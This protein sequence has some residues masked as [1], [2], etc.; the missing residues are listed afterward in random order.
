MNCPTFANFDEMCEKAKPDLLMVTTVDDFH[1]EYIVKGLDRGMDVMTEK[2]MVINEQQCQAVLDAEKRN[3]R[4]IIVTFN[5]RYAPKHRTVKEVLMSGEIGTRAVGRFRLVPRRLSRGGLLPPLAPAAQ[6]GGG[7]L[8]VHKATHHFDLVNW[9][10][11]ADPVEVVADG[12]LQRVRQERPFRHTNCR[13]CPH[14]KACRFHY[15]ITTNANRMKLYV[16]N[17]D[18]DQLLPRRLRVP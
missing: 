6:R 12:Q 11:A 8:F 4:K 14:K 9:W 10:L 2:P 3:N 7:S 15:D 1:H 17:E 5:Y 13:P 18:V 16:A